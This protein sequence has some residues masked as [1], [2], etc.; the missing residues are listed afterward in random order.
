M[1]EKYN[2]PVYPR[3]RGAHV[4]GGNALAC[5]FR[6]DFAPAGRKHD[7]AIDRLALR[8]RDHDRWRSQGA[9]TEHSDAEK[10]IAEK[11]SDGLFDIAA[12]RYYCFTSCVDEVVLEVANYQRHYYRTAYLIVFRT[13]VCFLRCDGR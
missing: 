7:D 4:R 8:A 12:L 3:R 1:A 11:W 5:G 10:D 2:V 9:G 6:A 13:L